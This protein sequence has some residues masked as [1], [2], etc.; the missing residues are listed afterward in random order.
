V[1]V[2]GATTTVFRGS[3]ISSGEITKQGRVF[4]ISAPW[5]GSRGQQ[6]LSILWMRVGEGF[7]PSLTQSSMGRDEEAL[8]GDPYVHNIAQATLRDERFGK[9]NATRVTDTDEFQAHI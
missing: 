9:P 2:I 3:F 6:H 7:F 1:L 5:D 4:L 8:R